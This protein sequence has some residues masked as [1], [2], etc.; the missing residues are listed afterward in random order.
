MGNQPRPE[1]AI[2]GQ[3]APMFSR[4]PQASAA[5]ILKTCERF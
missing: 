4:E 1:V 2:K 3:I 5:E